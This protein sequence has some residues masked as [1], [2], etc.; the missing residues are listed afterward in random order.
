L[1][2]RISTTIWLPSPIVVRRRVTAWSFAV[3]SFKCLDRVE[4][5]ST[6]HPIAVSENARAFT[7][8]ELRPLPAFQSPLVAAGVVAA[9]TEVV[10]KTKQ[11]E[12]VHRVVGDETI[13]RKFLAEF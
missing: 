1:A 2:T 5:A 9:A 10:T 3:A 12:S 11:V 7:G 13:Q 8:L 4:P 6:G